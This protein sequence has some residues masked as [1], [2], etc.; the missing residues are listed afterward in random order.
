[1]QY[2]HT[3]TN[4][5]RKLTA[6]GKKRETTM[7]SNPAEFHGIAVRI[8][9]HA[10]QSW[11]AAED[12]GR[13]LGYNEANARQGVNNLYSRHAD[14]F[15]EA[16]KAVIKLMTPGGMQATNIFSATGCTLLS[17]FANTPRAKDFRAWGKK[18]LAGQTPAP[19][20]PLTV[21]DRLDRLEANVGR[22]AEHMAA[23]V[24]VSH[25][26]AQ[27]LDVTARYI[28]LL[29][30]NQK[31]K[32]RITRATEA[33]VLAL[34]AQG[35]PNVDIARLLRISAASVSLLVHGKYTCSPEEAGRPPESVETH[36][37]RLIADERTA[38]LNYPQPLQ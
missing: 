2:I 5:S 18:V 9:E 20:A 35:M 10:G 28:G 3:L 29:E 37:E 1:V 14:E 19:A 32:V 33:Q 31:G 15:T 8:V 24:Q 30:I 23:L 26:Q 21:E 4:R 13:C 17:M 22:M 38:L 16:D 25:Q 6:D 7:T 27:K 36:L 34:K 12:V 11:L